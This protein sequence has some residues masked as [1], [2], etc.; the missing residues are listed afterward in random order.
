MR[1]FCGAILLL[2]LMVG[3]VLVAP[4]SWFR[5]A[6][7]EGLESATTAI[8]F[9]FGF[10]EDVDGNML[11]GAANSFLLDHVLTEHPQVDTV[12][13][14]EGIWVDQ[15]DHEELTC[16]VDDVRLLRIDWHDER[17]DLNTL[18]I[19][20]CV[21]ERMEL[22]QLD[23]AIVVAHDMQL[24]RA[25]GTLQRVQRGG[26][27][28]EC[29]LLIDNVPDT[30]YPEESAQLRTRSESVWRFIDLAAR[31]RDSHLMTWDTPDTCA[32][33]TPRTTLY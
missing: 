18:E 4:A 1:K 28:P 13:V 31:V 19:S 8:V 17:F 29:T 25:A 21:L 2:G 30:P 33:P 22:F 12:F 11:P 5:A 10:E 23:T 24:E 26:L 20:A 27:C 9:G 6:P 32:V 3:A 7:S 15:C 14:Q 16:T